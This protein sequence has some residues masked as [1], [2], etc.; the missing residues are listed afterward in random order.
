MLFE[1][2]SVGLHHKTQT[3]GQVLITKEM[4]WEPFNPSS[5]QREPEPW[6]FTYYHCNINLPPPHI[7]VLLLNDDTACSRL[8]F[9]NVQ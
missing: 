5:S 1:E 8:I 7:M 4:Q 6:N 2:S 9:L 3:S